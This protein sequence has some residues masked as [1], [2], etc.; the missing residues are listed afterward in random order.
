MG[1]NKAAPARSERLPAQKSPHSRL[2]RAGEDASWLCR[3]RS[4]AA[5]GAWAGFQ[6]ARMRIG[7]APIFRTQPATML[8]AGATNIK[9]A[10][11]AELRAGLTILI[12]TG[13][14][15]EKAVIA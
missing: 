1:P 7:C 15:Q 13:A 5:G 12:D 10:S 4:L 11:V 3:A 2:S 8:S 14:N 6:T 9:I